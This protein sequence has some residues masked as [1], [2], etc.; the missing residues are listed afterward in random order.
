MMSYP[1][2]LPDPSTNISVSLM[3]Q[4]CFTV[5]ANSS[6]LSDDADESRSDSYSN[7]RG[8]G[9]HSRNDQIIHGGQEDH[10][11]VSLEFGQAIQ[12]LIVSTVMDAL[13]NLANQEIFHMAKSADVTGE[14]IVGVITKCDVVSAHDEGPVRQ[15]AFLVQGKECIL[16]SRSS[17]SLRIKSTYS[18]MVGSLSEICQPG[19][20]K[21]EPPLPNDMRRRQ[22]SSNKLLGLNCQGIESEFQL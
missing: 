9:Y 21:R 18:D 15:A 16:I 3:F 19:R 20:R 8:L 1:S 2:S 17:K 14:R 5:R 7:L 4:V 11:A 6:R 10:H 22:N 13:N 12:P